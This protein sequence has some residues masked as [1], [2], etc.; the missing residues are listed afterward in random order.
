MTKAQP[1]YNQKNQLPVEQ[2]KIQ[3]Q[4]EPTNRVETKEIQEPIKKEAPNAEGIF[5]NKI[6]ILGY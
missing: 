5:L 6:K 4:D 3:H 1:A 2:P